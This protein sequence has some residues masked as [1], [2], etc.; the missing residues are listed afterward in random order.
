M[1]EAPSAPG[2]ARSRGL[3]IVLSSPSGAGKTTL[4]RRLL[5]EFD[6]TAFSVSYTTRPPRKNERDGIDYHFVDLDGFQRMIDAGEF[7][8]WAEVHGN[9]YGTAKTTVESALADGRDVIFDIDWQGGRSLFTQWPDDALM[10][11]VVPPGLDILEARLR[12]R[13]TDAEDVIQRR[14]AKAVDE[15]R[16]HREYQHVVVNDDLD[17]AYQLLKAIYLTR[18]HSADASVDGPA[19]ADARQVLAGHDPEGARQQ[20][21]AML[22]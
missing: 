22:S 21:D 6:R 7:A 12:G 11:F 13:G 4:A 10:V 8:E 16:H 15:M 3:L 14:L 1:P 17:R 2:S 19:L 18:R 9:R 20:A 5:G